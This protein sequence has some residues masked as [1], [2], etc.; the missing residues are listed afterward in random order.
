MQQKKTVR[1]DRPYRA[2][3]CDALLYF[4]N[5]VPSCSISV[6]LTPVWEAPWVRAPD[7][8]HSI[9]SYLSFPLSDIVYF[10][11]NTVVLLFLSFRPPGLAARISR[12]SF[13][14]FFIRAQC[15]VSRTVYIR[16]L[17]ASGFS[18]RI[19]TRMWLL[20]TFSLPEK[21]RER[22][23]VREKSVVVLLC[24]SRVVCSSAR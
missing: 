19:R 2:S 6:N 5:H 1:S 15:V 3:R 11:T 23:R 7:V 14:F 8:N 9:S 4:C 12:R 10:I 16:R 21:G 24:R 13:L 22:E 18:R 20:Q 17:S